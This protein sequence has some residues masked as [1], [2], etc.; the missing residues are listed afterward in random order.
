M[1]F[2]NKYKKYIWAGILGIVVGNILDVM[3]SG[4]VDW[5]VYGVVAVG[6]LVLTDMTLPYFDKGLEKLLGL[7]S[8][9]ATAAG[10]VAEEVKDTATDAK[11][12]VKKTVKKA[13]KKAD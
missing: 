13:A 10:D 9:G 5:V 2:V 3:L 4:A 6:A 11:K 1:D 7:F 12:A 8:K